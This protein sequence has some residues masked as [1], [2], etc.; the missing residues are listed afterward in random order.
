MT[1]QKKSKKKGATRGTSSTTTF[2]RAGAVMLE[3]LQ[4]WLLR[5]S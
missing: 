1:R 5:D 3:Q 4:L 2:S